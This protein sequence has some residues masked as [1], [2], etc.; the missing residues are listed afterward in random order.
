M[1][2]CGTGRQRH[3]TFN[4]TSLGNGRNPAWGRRSTSCIEAVAEDST[5]QTRLKTV[6][7]FPHDPCCFFP[8]DP[9]FYLHFITSPLFL[10]LKHSS[11]PCFHEQFELSFFSNYFESAAIYRAEIKLKCTVF[12]GSSGLLASKTCRLLSHSAIT[13]RCS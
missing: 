6:L 4:L 10:P 1:L 7:P 9:N 2:G 12:T 5:Y 3:A 8:D 11:K 13:S